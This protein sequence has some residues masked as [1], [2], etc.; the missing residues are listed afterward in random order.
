[1]RK[2]L[3]FMVPAYI[4]FFLLG[5]F[6]FF[7][8]LELFFASAWFLDWLHPQ[9]LG[10]VILHVTAEFSAGLAAASVLLADNS[11]GA[12]EVVLALL[13]G[14]ILAAPVRAIRHQLPYYMGIFP[15]KLAM[16]LIVM[17][18]FVRAICIILIGYCFYLFSMGWGV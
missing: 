5:R 13:V 8:R 9:S 7:E 4:L 18:Q 2:I 1:M 16:K 10:I 17:S 15:A 11:L 12:R 6:G 3:L 14:N